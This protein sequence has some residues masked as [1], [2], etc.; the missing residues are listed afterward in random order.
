M[1]VH[2]SELHLYPVKSAGG[3]PL[4]EVVV[5]PWGILGDRRW[6][7]IDPDGGNVTAREESRLLSVRV[8]V[9]EHDSIVVSAADC[10]PLAVAVPVEGASVATTL[11]RVGQVVDAGEEAARWFSRLFE[12]PLRLVW[13]D[14]PRRRPLTERHGGEPGDALSLADAG[15]LLITTSRSLVQLDEWI[16]EAA[17]QRGDEQP[18]PMEMARFRPNVVV[19]GVET[20]FAEDS[21]QRLRVGDVTLRRGE[22]CD[23]CVMTT[24]DPTS[25]ARGKEPIRTLAAHRRW[26][27]A[28]WFGVRFVPEVTGTIRLGDP[29]TV[30]G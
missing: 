17:L 27:G 3:L 14:D 18:A 30:A 13:Q 6:M 5:Q 28:V 29:V 21:W 1:A 26:D 15:P 16:A 8:A 25:L 20:P 12:R 11:S 7:L 22:S 19:E 9:G 2:V 24:I 10:A 23:R 4:S